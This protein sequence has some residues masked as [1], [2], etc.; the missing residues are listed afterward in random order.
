M[1]A[2]VARESLI[3]RDAARLGYTRR[4]AERAPASSQP[5]RGLVRPVSSP[6]GL[7]L[8]PV[9]H[10]SS[11]SEE[12]HAMS[13]Q[14]PD[15]PERA[16]QV[17]Q[18]SRMPVHKYQPFPAIGLSDRTWPDAVITEAPQWCSVDLRD[19]NQALIDPMSPARKR[20]M[21]QLLVDMGFKEIEV[22]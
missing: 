17:Q 7:V 22:G 21:F 9:T 13:Q 2:D 11:R 6:R 10:S 1:R 18:P 20:K 3:L 16:P 19:G 8:P 14:S 15:H 4:D 12:T 5:R